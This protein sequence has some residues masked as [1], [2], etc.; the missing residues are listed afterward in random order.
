MEG[1][2]K[3][4]SVVPLNGDQLASSNDLSDWIGGKKVVSLSLKEFYGWFRYKQVFSGL[5]TVGT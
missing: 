5:K 4:V 2:Q 1:T 3:W